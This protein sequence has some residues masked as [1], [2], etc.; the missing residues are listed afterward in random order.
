MNNDQIVASVSDGVARAI[1]NI[2]FEMS[3]FR[4]PEIDM[5]ALSGAIQYAVVSALANNATE[6]PIDV[7]ATLRT[8][9]DEVL[10]R[11]VARGNRSMNYRSQAVAT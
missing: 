1:S 11:A 8:E 10:A 9:N 7:Y 3:N 6:R 5:S 4:P 2:R